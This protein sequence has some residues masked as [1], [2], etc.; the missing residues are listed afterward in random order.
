MQDT[1]CTTGSCQQHDRLSSLHPRHLAPKPLWHSSKTQQDGHCTHTR[2]SRQ[3][4]H[5]LPQ[6]SRCTSQPTSCSLHCGDP[7]K[8]QPQAPPASPQTHSAS[9]WMTKPPQTYL[10]TSVK[11]LPK[12]RSLRTLPKP[13]V[14][15]ELWTLRN[16]VEVRGL[17]IGDVLRRV[18]SRC[19]AQVFASHIHTACNPHQICFLHPCWQWGSHPC[20]HHRHRAR[21]HQHHPFH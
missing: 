3:R 13:L 12:P 15:Y 1:E 7:E 17:V 10:S 21:A 6:N 14:W 16:Q 18:A 9:F 2:L 8:E 19:L 11:N 5:G 20:A 4:A